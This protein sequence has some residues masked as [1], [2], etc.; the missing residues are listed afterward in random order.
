MSLS[1]G[2]GFLGKALKYQ[3]QCA[4]LI[5]P[6]LVFSLLVFHWS[7][8]NGQ[9]LSHCRKELHKCMHTRTGALVGHQNSSY[10]F[11]EEILFSV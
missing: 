10:R 4:S 9:S 5:K 8:S 1:S 11:Q 6:L 7:K 3:L 2:F